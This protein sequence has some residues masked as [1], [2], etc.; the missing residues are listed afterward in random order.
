M[1]PGRSDNAAWQSARADI[2]GNRYACETCEKRMTCVYGYDFERNM[3]LM[4]SAWLQCITG[5][6]RWWAWAGDACI[7]I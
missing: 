7:G 2:P 5:E 3:L 1:I 4:R 6:Q